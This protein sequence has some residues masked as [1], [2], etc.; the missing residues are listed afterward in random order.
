M[1]DAMEKRYKVKTDEGGQAT[2]AQGGLYLFYRPYMVDAMEKRYKVKPDEAVKRPERR[3]LNLA[4][5]LGLLFHAGE[6][7][8]HFEMFACIF[9]YLEF[10]GKDLIGCDAGILQGTETV[11]G[12]YV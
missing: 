4:S 5:Y 1:V 8:D 9:D 6:G 10:A 7:V 12:E 2:E 3:G 11:V